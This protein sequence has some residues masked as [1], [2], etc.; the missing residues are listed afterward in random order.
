[1]KFLLVALVLM[2]SGTVRAAEFKLQSWKQPPNWK[3]QMVAE[4]TL[5]CRSKIPGQSQAK[6]TLRL[7]PASKNAT[8]ATFHP[9]PSRKIFFAQNHNIHG[10]TWV[11]ALHQDAQGTGPLIRSAQTLFTFDRK[12][13][14]FEVVVEAPEE[15]YQ[16]I[17]SVVNRSI[18]SLRL[19]NAK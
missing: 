19:P 10:R 8:L 15:T 9:S 5:N 4:G 12:K 2:A 1:M 6:M 7:K 11:D 13:M 16:S 14:A 18:A 3:C 17:E